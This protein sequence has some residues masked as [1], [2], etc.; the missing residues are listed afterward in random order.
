MK[1]SV[2]KTKVIC[3]SSQKRTKIKI[4]I[5]GH[6]VEEVWM[7]L[8]IG[9]LTG[10]PIAKK[11]YETGSLLGRKNFWKLLSNGL[12]LTYKND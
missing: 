5:D 10:R 1:M 4:L 6:R 8:N 2:K 12:N 3:T 9:L 7:N 11:T